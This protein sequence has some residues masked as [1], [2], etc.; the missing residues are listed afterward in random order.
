MGK[1]WT[2][3]LR[4]FYWHRIKGIKYFSVGGKITI[5]RKNDIILKGKSYFGPNCYL[6][7]NIISDGD[8]LVGPSVCFVG[9][10][11]R[12]PEREENI[13]YFDSGRAN[14]K[15]IYIEN[16]VWIG[17][18]CTILSGITISEGTIIAAG[19]VLT[20]TTEP[21]SI[22]GSSKLFKIKTIK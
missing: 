10:D 16:N 13:S 12:I 5:S 22:Y 17:A 18:N 19:T 9:D 21:F 1:F 3:I 20:K 11:H 2:Y 14:L 15:T 4:L 6:G 7:A 8:L